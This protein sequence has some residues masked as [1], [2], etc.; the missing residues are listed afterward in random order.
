MTDYREILRLSK[1][2]LNQTSIRTAL[3]YSRNTISDVLHRAQT[4]GIKYPLPDNM[5]DKEFQNLLYPEKA[6]ENTHKMPD[7]GKI[8]KELAK[9]GVTLTLLWDEYC[10]ECRQNGEIPYAFTQFRVHYH[11]YV[12][13]TKAVMHIKHKPGE[14][15]EVDW[16]GSTMT[17]TNNI[18]G[19]PIP[20]YVFAAALPYSSYTYVEAFMTQNEESWIA[21]NIHALEFFGGSTRI[22]RPDNL[23]TGV[24]EADYYEPKINKSY[25]ELAEYYGCAVIPARAKRPRDKAVI[26]NS[27]GIA[28][29]WVIASLRTRKFFSIAEVNEAIAE[30]LR[31]YNEK[32]FQKRPGSRLS[33]FL[34]EEKEYLQPLPNERYEL[35]V[36]K[37]VICGYNYHVL[38]DKNYYSVPYEYIKYELEI[39]LTSTTVEVFFNN[40]RICSHPR[41]HGKIE[42]YSTI[43]EHMPE[44]HKR[45]A[46][47]NSDSFTS[48]AETIGE[49]TK[50]VIK[51]ILSSHKVEQ[52]GYRACLGVMKLSDK[53]GVERLERACEKA[54]SY[55]PNPSYKNIES[56]LNSGSD[57]LIKPNKEIKPAIDES[58]SYIRGAAYYG[59]K[60]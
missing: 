28:T 53:H 44:K 34:E 40:H 59:R 6:S 23:R 46:E 12:E 29:T 38:V 30:K 58:H 15:M 43:P 42:Q 51:S 18:T 16:A 57:K 52:Q 4:K 24:T 36:W 54:L 55:T 20:A 25:Q 17:V 33:A 31:E 5:S 26:E 21:A 41:I 22:I 2:G 39:R 45:S 48:W 1:I 60:R 14:V 27:I 19:E 47:W 3:G 50:V 49:N 35:A 11:Q 9:S 37:K 32:P 13:T 8:H 56:I 7:Y 10:K